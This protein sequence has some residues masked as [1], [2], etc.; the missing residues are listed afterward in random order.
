MDRQSSPDPGFPPRGSALARWIVLGLL[1][2]LGACTVGAANYPLIPDGQGDVRQNVRLL[3]AIRMESRSVDGLKFVGLSGL[4]WDEDEQLLYAISDHGRLFH[5]RIHV[6]NDRLVA[7]E[8]V[9]GHS[10][11]DG[12]GRALRYPW[13]DAE[14]LTLEHGDDGRRGNSEL[15]VSFEHRPRVRVY[16]MRGRRLRAESLPA[17]LEDRHRYAHPNRSLESIT[18][19]P[20][21]GLLV[22]PEQPLRGDE[23]LRLYGQDGRAWRYALRSAPGSA[24]VALEALPDGRLLAL[25]RAFVAPYLPFEISLREVEL[26]PDDDRAQVLDLAVFSTA[27]G[28][29]L[30][31]FEGL[32]RHRG[33]R[34]FMVSDDN[35]SVWQATLLVY[36]AWLPYEGGQ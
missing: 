17:P 32:A 12:D 34:F 14:G 19:H 5:L 25:E 28:W 24:L 18:R 33:R 3:G 21:H 8:V 23:T 26:I 10:L 4:A 7:A 6:D 27:D 15:L 11:T 9:A 30:D 13:S 1:G 20:R 22:A 29:R 16:D 35:D 31:N 2:W 36:F